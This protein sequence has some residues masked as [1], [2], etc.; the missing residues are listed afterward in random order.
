MLRNG[1]SSHSPSKGKEKLRSDRG[2]KERCEPTIQI[3]DLS[4]ERR[5][6]AFEIMNGEFLAF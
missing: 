6:Q 3:E 1:F 5:V 4:G 2:F